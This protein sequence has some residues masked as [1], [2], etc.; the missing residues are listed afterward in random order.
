MLWRGDTD[1]IYVLTHDGRWMSYPNEWREGA[2]EFSCGDPDP[3]TTPVRGFGRVW[4]DHPDIR[5]AL[6]P[7]TAA[8]IGD[9]AAV[10]QDFVNGI[11]LIAPFGDPFVLV[12][13]SG[14]WRRVEE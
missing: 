13:E 10:V 2:P 6:G 11:I 14:V 9:N 7:V 12:G 4:C 1:L 5:Q 3:L 8:E